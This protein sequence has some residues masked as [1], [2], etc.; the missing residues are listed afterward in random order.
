LDQG[1]AVTRDTCDTFFHRACSSF[2]L[3]VALYRK[4]RHLRHKR[5]KPFFGE[6]SSSLPPTVDI[7]QLGIGVLSLR[8]PE[9]A[10]PALQTDGATRTYRAGA[11][12]WSKP[13]ALYLT[14]GRPRE[15]G[16][17]VASGCDRDRPPAKRAMWPLA[18]AV[19]MLRA[20]GV[21]V[22]RRAHRIRKI[23]VPCP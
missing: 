10:P 16:R 23:D 14:L 22:H 17:N 2:N 13:M 21:G 3:N 1:R 18:R 5:H 19:S 15:D 12:A 8:G 6:T 11:M 20:G 7:R 4:V 9:V